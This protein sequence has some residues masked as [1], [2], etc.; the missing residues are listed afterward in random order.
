ML[1]GLTQRLW[2]VRREVLWMLGGLG[3]GLLAALVAGVLV[4]WVQPAVQ[5]ARSPLASLEAKPIVLRYLKASP[6]ADDIPKAAREVQRA[7]LRVLDTLGIAEEELGRPVYVY[8]YARLEELP[9]GFGARSAEM[10][11]EVALTDHVRGAPLE[12]ALGRV[13]AS[14]LFARPRNLVLPRGLALYLD[15][16]EYPWAAE[17][18]AWAEELDL[19]MLWDEADRL[20]PRDPLEDLYFSVNAPWETLAPSLEALRILLRTGAGSAQERGRAAQALSAALV[21]WVLMEWGRG[22]LELFWRAPTLSAVADAVGLERAELLRAF[23]SHLAE[24]F[25][26]SGDKEYLEGLRLLYT[27]RPRE[28]LDRLMPLQGPEVAELLAQAHLALGEPRAALEAWGP[29][30]PADLA[31][32]LGE[33]ADAPRTARGQLLLVGPAHDAAVHLDHALESV[34]RALDF[35]DHDTAVLPYRIVFYLVGAPPADPVPW[36][37]LWVED[38]AELPALAV[39]TVLEAVSPMGVPR[40]TTL[41]QGLILHL[42]EPHR[43]FAAEAR[44]QLQEERR[45]VGLGQ[46]LFGVYPQALAEAQSGAL[47]RYLLEVHGR[48]GLRAMWESLDRGASPFS[49][50]L[51]VFGVT[52]SQLEENLKNWLR[53]L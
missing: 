4:F 19:A 18:G 39:R 36:G 32:V 47:V 28:A 30:V 43:D 31:Q 7:M 45:W 29:A 24:A 6:P 37:V 13:A 26:A 35:W 50:S 44:R 2:L 33:L 16:P 5:R 40:Y 38:P 1:R 20:L 48:A 51:E 15:Q 25:A 46:T 9:A 52:L 41:V 17:A 21:E 14:L 49:A 12:G 27:G 11:T 53:G 3:L 10:A 22:G 34:H 23:S 42:T 8:L